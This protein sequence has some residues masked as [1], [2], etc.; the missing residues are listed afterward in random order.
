MDIFLR[1]ADGRWSRRQEEHEEFAYRDEE[2]LDMLRRAGF[3]QIR[4][5]GELKLRAPRPGEGRV[6][7]AARKEFK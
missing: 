7:Y 5:Y 1:E 6:F 2:L 4:R 3:R